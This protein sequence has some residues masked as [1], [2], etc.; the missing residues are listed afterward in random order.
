MSNTVK[1]PT[2]K[3]LTACNKAIDAIAK[4]FASQDNASSLL[5]EVLALVERFFARVLTKDETR[6]I[7]DGVCEK[8]G[9]EGRTAI[10]RA[11]EIRKVL[12]V[13]RILPAAIAAFCKQ[14]VT[15]TCGWIPAVRLAGQLN[16]FMGDSY[17]G[18]KAERINSA[19]D[20]MLTPK[21]AGKGGG[22][23]VSKAAQYTR[24]AK[25]VAELSKLNK[26]P[27]GFRDEMRTLHI[28]YCGE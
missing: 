14:N 18:T 25:I 24:A 27:K 7:A 4:T 12:R 11:S 21:V 6:Y 10:N 26:L 28:K 8:R 5:L 13:H 3:A 15:G 17:N 19:V 16:T 20:V 23:P 2:G 9:Y 22:T 1:T